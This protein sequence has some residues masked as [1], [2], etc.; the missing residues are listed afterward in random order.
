ME[1]A[2]HDSENDNGPG[3]ILRFL[4]SHSTEY[5]SGRD[6]SDVLGISRVAVWKQI[7]TIRNL[8]YGVESKQKIGY[9]LTSECDIPYPWEII[10]GLDTRLVGR[11]VYYYDTLESTQ[12]KAISMDLDEANDGAVIISAVQTNA[13][14]RAKK[15]WIS[16]RGGIWFSVILHPDFDT[17]TS[18]L[19]PLGAGTAI[20]GAIKHVLGAEVQLR[21]PNDVTLAGK[22]VAGIITE[23]EMELD[24]IYKI[25]IGVGINFGI[26]ART[27]EEELASRDEFYGAASLTTTPTDRCVIETAS[28]DMNGTIKTRITLIREIL[29]RLDS[30]YDALAAGDTHKIIS[31]WSKRSS[32]IGQRIKTLMGNQVITGTATGIS[33]NGMLIV[34]TDDDNTDTDAGKQ[35]RLM[36]GSLSY[37]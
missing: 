27:I 9:K 10:D 31:E 13:R 20:A 16:P 34:E 21:W 12:D 15:R 11:R 5:L 24:R 29:R 8:G 3:R 23:A 36:S 14:G 28:T 35:I 18:T 30:V 37:I 4:K 7:N 19:L 25:C 6:L 32:T 1:N 17:T 33:E 26:D 2:L 22:K